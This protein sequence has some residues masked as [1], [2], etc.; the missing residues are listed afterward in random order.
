MAF[1]R[2]RIGQPI[3]EGRFVGFVNFKE[4]IFESG[5]MVYL[6]RNTLVMNI[7]SLSIGLSAAMVLAIILNETRILWF[8]KL[9]QTASFQC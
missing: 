4:F 5:D 1:T 8:K 6:L 2:H 3:L 7:L 9:V